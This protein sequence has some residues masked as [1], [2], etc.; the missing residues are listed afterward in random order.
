M[1]LP[2]CRQAHYTRICR[3]L[4]TWIMEVLCG[5]DSRYVGRT[6]TGGL[7]L[8]EE[9]FRQGDG[10]VVQP[11]LAVAF[12]VLCQPHLCSAG[13]QRHG[14]AEVIPPLRVGFDGA[15]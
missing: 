13:R 3:I 2:T 12:E 11:D 15:Q 10:E 14:L 7:S 1:G 5:Q 6:T 4:N 9:R 8:R